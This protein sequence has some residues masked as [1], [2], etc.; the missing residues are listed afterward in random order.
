MDALF[1]V[2]GCRI[3]VVQSLLSISRTMF[4]GWS[5]DCDSTFGKPEA[6]SE[7]SDRGSREW[8]V[9]W[10]ARALQHSSSRRSH[11]YPCNC[12][13]QRVLLFFLHRHCPR[14][15]L[16]LGSDPGTPRVSSSAC[17][18]LRRLQGGNAAS[19][20]AAAAWEAVAALPLVRCAP[21]RGIATN[22]VRSPPQSRALTQPRPSKEAP[23][24]GAHAANM[25]W[26][27]LGVQLK[28][29][30]FCV[31]RWGQATVPRL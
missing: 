9:H 30:V 20:A 18:S 15:C 23:R 12:L 5:R 24:E 6:T 27:S 31:C 29:F 28:A 26:R 1:A 14:R 7:A 19:A 25:V 16:H 21:A 17:R 3:S 13:P 22:L 8:L 2:I 4:L 10:G 11:A